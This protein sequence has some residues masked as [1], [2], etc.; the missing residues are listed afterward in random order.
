MKKKIPSKFLSKKKD[1]KRTPRNR[2]LKKQYKG[3][4]KYKSDVRKSNHEEKFV[5]FP[6]YQFKQKSNLKTKASLPETLTYFL[7]K[8]KSFADN[9]LVFDTNIFKIPK[10]FS[11]IEDYNETTIFLNKLFNSLYNQSYEDIYIDYSECEQIDVGASMCMDIILSEFIKYFEN[12]IKGNHKV[13]I[14]KIRPINFERYDIEKILFSIGAYRN[15]KGFKL[16]NDKILDFPIL[17]GNKQNP[18]LAEEREVHITKTVDYIIDCL[19][20]L[21]KTLTGPAETNLYKTI[22]EILQNADEHSDTNY[23]YSIGYFEKDNEKDNNYGVFNLAI[24]NFGNTFYET[25][26]NPECNNIEV[27]EQ[28]KNLSQ[29]YTSWSLFKKNSFEEETLWT[30]YALQDGVT[31]I[32]D[33]ERGNGAIRFIESFFKLKGNEECDNISKMTLTSGHTRIIFDGNYQIVEKERGKENKKFKMMTFNESGNIEELPDSKYVKHETNY[34][35]GT[36]LS[37]K[38]RI[39]FNNTENI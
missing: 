26:K 14:A 17:I 39:D 9:K 27:V 15:I 5:N 28:M 36:L 2:L 32:A 34:F 29:K 30:L 4:Y 33:W 6:F 18:R 38:I 8:E 20:T 37:A 19:K 10:I 1:R 7:N 12:L 16:N 22:G 35:P 31:R 3:F 23:R 24:L 21:N 11:I 25:F 13:K